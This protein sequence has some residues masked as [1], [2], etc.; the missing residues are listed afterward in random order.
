VDS[1]HRPVSDFD[2]PHLNGVLLA[3]QRNIWIPWALVE[4]AE[5]GH[6]LLTESLRVHLRDGRRV[7]LLWLAVDH[8]ATALADPLRDRLGDRLLAG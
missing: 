3:S 7:A 5:I 2:L 4:S 1:L 8:G 6:R